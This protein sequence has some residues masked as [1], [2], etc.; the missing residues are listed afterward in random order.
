M[1]GPS[2]RV[3]GFQVAGRSRGRQA[4]AEIHARSKPRGKDRAEDE[5]PRGKDRAGRKTHRHGDR[6]A[7][8]GHGGERRPR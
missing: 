8:R 1:A 3:R 2:D 5:E 4:R 6:E 7:S